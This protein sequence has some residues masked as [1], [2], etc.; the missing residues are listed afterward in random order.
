MTVE[1]VRSG[2]LLARKRPHLVPVYDNVVREP[3]MRGR[4][5]GVLG[6][7]RATGL[8][9]LRDEAGATSAKFSLARVLHVAL[10]MYGRRYGT[11]SVPYRQRNV[12]A[13]MPAW[14]HK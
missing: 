5:S 9:N 10:W 11:D 3:S 13:A 6:P 8:A 2:K 12:T 1:W 4:A 14:S 7:S